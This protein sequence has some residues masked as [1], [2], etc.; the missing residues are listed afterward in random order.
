M[1]REHDDVRLSDIL[2]SDQLYGS[3]QNEMEFKMVKLTTLICRQRG[4]VVISCFCNEYG[5]R[6]LAQVARSSP[7]C[8]FG[9]DAYF[10][11][12]IFAKQNKTSSKIK[13]TWDNTKIKLRHNK[14]IKEVLWV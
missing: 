12:L 14:K 7:F 9:Y 8:V 10:A 6:S 3:M 4:R 1:L 5:Q 11:I 2:I 13:T